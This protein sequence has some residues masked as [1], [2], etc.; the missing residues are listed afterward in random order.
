MTA[1][2]YLV[3]AAAAHGAATVTWNFDVTTTGNDVF[4]DPATPVNPNAAE[5]DTTLQVTQVIVTG[6]WN[7]IP[8][9]LLDVTS[10]IPPADLTATE[11]LAG[12]PPVTVVEA[13]FVYPP[14]PDPAGIAATIFTEIDV[15]GFG[16]GSMTG[17]TL[18]D[19]QM[20]V[21]PFGAVTVTLTSLRVVGLVQVTEVFAPADTDESGAVDVFD[22]LNVLGDWG[23]CDQPC[24]PS[25]ASDITNSTGTGTD[26]N[27][28]V[29]DLLAVLNG[30]G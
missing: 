13:P 19:V 11:L 3:A 20:N 1:T 5:F 27:V 30:W 22:L 26:C 6:V 9:G 8:I 14:P 17:V 21:P 23:A 4:F 7:A 16:H 25:C 24:P 28:N 10:E 15:N 29:F 2:T 18:G 12:P